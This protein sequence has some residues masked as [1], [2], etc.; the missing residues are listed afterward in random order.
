MTGG[1]LFVILGVWWLNIPEMYN[2]AVVWLVGGV[3][4]L[5]GGFI[6]LRKSSRE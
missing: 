4:F 3:V 6:K 5:I 1:V 2:G